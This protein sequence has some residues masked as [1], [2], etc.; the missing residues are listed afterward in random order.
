[1]YSLHLTP[2]QLEIRD[3]VRAF[4]TKEL[5][6]LAEKPARM[7]ARDRSPLAGVLAAAAELGLKTLALPEDM[8]GAGGDAL[9]AV[10]VAEE[11]AAGDCD[12][13]AILATTSA[14]ARALLG[15]LA[16][17]GQRDMWLPKVVDAQG[18]LAW[19]RGLANTEI[20]I[21]Y[22][23]QAA[24]AE[25]TVTATRQGSSY[26]L[27]GTSHGVANAPVASLVAV[28]ATTDAKSRRPAGLVALVVPRG[29]AGMTITPLVH[30]R[31]LG[32]C[33]DIT[34][35]DCKVPA[36]H[37]V[38]GADGA[39]AATALGRLDAVPIQAAV[40]LGIGRACYEAAIDYA[41]LRVQGGR[42]II[43]H[44]AIAEKLASSAVRLETARAAIWAAAWAA[45]HPEAVTDGSLTALP[46]P[47][48]A[49]I[50]AAEQVY[51]AAKDCAECFGAM[52]VMRDMPLHKYVEDTRRFLHSDGGAGE[53]KLALAE[54]IAGFRRE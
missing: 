54:A 8:G 41:R 45:D 46:L 20:G 27:N 17:P 31:F 47:R 1:M 26:V 23:R 22:H 18:Q 36:D 49:H 16:S 34:F 14:V 21:N 38:G 39:A 40:A 19:A 32:S 24:T 9:T 4:A 28:S 37:L 3:T 30:G 12:T 2:E 29:T 13:A 6:P 33:G 53:H 43:E 35:K 51:R 10:I 5:K 11:L 50:H 25:A 48:I 15:E 52:G 7:E 42:P 44:Q